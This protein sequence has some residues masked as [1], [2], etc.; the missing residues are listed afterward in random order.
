MTTTATQGTIEHIDP[1]T[2]TVETNARTTVTLD[3]EFVES[4]R[5]NGVLEPVIGYRT[6]DG[7]IVVRMGQRRVRAAQQVE[8]PTVPV[9]LVEASDNTSERLFDQ[10]IENIHRSEMTE[11]DKA[12]AFQQLA[13]EGISV[14]RIAKRLSTKPA[15]VKSALTVAEN[16]TASAALTEHQLTFD[17]A[18]ALIEFEGEPEVIESLIY[19]ATT[20]P[21]QFAHVTQRARDEL[22]IAQAKAEAIDSLKARGFEVLA[23]APGYYEPEYTKARELTTKEGNEVDE[24]IL[25]TVATRA[26]HVRMYYT[27]DEAEIDYYVKDAKAAGFKKKKSDGSAAQPMT[28]DQKAERRELIANNKAWGSAEIV[29]RE[30]LTTFLSRKTLP[31]DAAKMIALGLTLHRYPVSTHMGHGNS[32]AHTLLGLTSKESGYFT[33]DQ[34]VSYLETNPARVQHV[35]LAVVLGG[36]ES[37]TSKNTWRHPDEASRAYFRQLAA[38]GY[39]LSEVENILAE[40]PV[41]ADSTTAE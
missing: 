33:T 10:L 35:S 40:L 36:I 2:I 15:Q 27:S 18:A 23:S 16:A 28:D 26:A 12:T 30:W 3:E 34:F 24:E 19:T 29:R 31:K 7:Q 21:T 39:A 5:T 6:A 22:R 37:S 14:A 41:V 9:Y 17:Q 20:D 1:S 11:S 38:W 32:L 25:A 8:R 4:I 13:F